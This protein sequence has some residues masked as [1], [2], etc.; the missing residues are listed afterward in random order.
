MQWTG[1][2]DDDSLAQALRTHHVLVVPSRYEG[3]GIVTLEAMGFGVVPVASRAGG[4]PEIV[5]EGSGIL[6]P[7][8]RS[9]ALARALRM[10]ATDRARLSALSAGA[11]RR[12]A[13]FAGWQ[14]SMEA[15]RTFLGE[16]LEAR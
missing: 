2:L 13:A 10:L 7:V 9:R 3:F 5:D 6:F 1:T 11:R 16:Q 15:A 12:F 14:A 4:T 8:G